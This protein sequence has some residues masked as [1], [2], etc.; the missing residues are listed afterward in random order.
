MSEKYSCLR[1]RTYH[2][3]LAALFLIPMVLITMKTLV[4]GYSYRNILPTTSYDVTLNMDVEAFGDAVDVSVFLPGGNERQVI[5]DEV[6]ESG[7]FTLAAAADASGRK[8]TWSTDLL[9]GK[10]AV[11]CQFRVRSEAVEYQLD[12]GL[13]I[14]RDLPPSVARYLEPTGTIQSNHPQILAHAEAL[15]G[16]DE[17]MTRV[18]RVLFDDVNAMGNRP[19]KGLTDALTAFKLQE[20]SCNGKSRL[21]VALCRNRGIPSRLA[22]GLILD[23]GSKRTSHQWAEVYMGGYWVPFDALNG[24][25]AAIPANY[26]ELYKGDAFLFSHSANVGFD[27]LFSI[28]KGLISNPRLSAELSDSGWNSYEM[29]HAFEQAGI[30]LSLLKVILLIPLGAMV[31]AIARNVI[32]LKTFGVFLPALIAVSISNTGLWWGIL[33]FVLVIVLVSLMHFPLER[34]GMLYTPKLVIMLVTVVIAFIG[35]SVLGIRLNYSDLAYITL[36]PVVV[37]TITAERFA[38]TVME[39]GFPRALVIT[40]QTLVV[41]LM[42]YLAMQS[43]TMEA[44]FLAFPE[45]FLV[46]IGIMLL[47]GRWMGLRITEYRRFRWLA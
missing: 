6:Q 3:S 27:Y 38:R 1:I 2:I 23:N 33:A 15:V 29:W 7:P 44:V 20:A 46:I 40:A 35:L 22:G 11:S 10:H 32:G 45:L 17:R 41:V 8:V 34:L 39:E 43:R 28:R 18:L 25:F 21:F 37:I 4:L 30:P 5:T 47:L 19:F 36:F 9:T 14:P 16:G 13:I 31:V 42:A 26:L 24:H 12:S